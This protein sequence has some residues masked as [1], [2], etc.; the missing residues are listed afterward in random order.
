M[1]I[2][3]YLKKRKHIDSW[4]EFHKSLSLTLDR[5]NNPAYVGLIF[6]EFAKLYFIQ[7]DKFKHV[8]LFKEIPYDLRKELNLYSQDIGV[9][10][11]LIDYSNNAWAIQ[12]KF[13]IDK[14]IKLSWSKD[15]LANLFAAG[16]QSDYFLVFSSGKSLDNRT[17][18]TYPDNL[19]TVLIDDL[20][21]LNKIDF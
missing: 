19:F 5:S 3:K 2:F 14:T 13:K 15:K 20:E 17:L 12:C 9:D 16:Y 7:K 11:L 6:E 1:E 18:S 21:Q 4:K 8:W 10:L